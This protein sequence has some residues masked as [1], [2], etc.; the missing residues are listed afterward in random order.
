MPTDFEAAGPAFNDADVAL[1]A[2]QHGLG[3][4]L[5]RLSLAWPRLQS[6][7]LVMASPVVCRAPRDNWLILREDS[8]ALPA[9]RH[10]VQWIRGQAADWRAQMD[11]F[12]A[13]ALPS[14]PSS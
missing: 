13:D 3:V 11:Q 9:V 6:G 12:D 5:T 14:R 10:F 8:A 1:D 4:A 7:Q 2:A